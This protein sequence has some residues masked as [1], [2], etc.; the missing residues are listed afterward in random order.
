M[1]GEERGG[2]QKRVEGRGGD[3][4]RGEGRGEEGKVNQ[5]RFLFILC[6]NT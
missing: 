4:R 1:K 2:D 6:P 3:E 5:K